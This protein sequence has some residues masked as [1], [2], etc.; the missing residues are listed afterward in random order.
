MRLPSKLGR[1]LLEAS[2]EG[3]DPIREAEILSRRPVKTISINRFAGYRGGY[4]FKILEIAGVDVTPLNG[5]DRYVGIV[6]EGYELLDNAIHRGGGYYIME[7][8]SA[9]LHLI[10]ER[11]DSEKGVN[12]ILDVAAAP[13]GKTFIAA[14]TYLESTIVA[15]EPNRARHRRLVNNVIRNCLHN[16]WVSRYRGEKLPPSG[17]YDLVIFDAPCSGLDLL[18]KRPRDVVTNL[19]HREAYANL[20]RTIVRHISSMVREGGY[21]VYST[22]TLTREE[23]IDVYWEAVENGWEPID[24]GSHLPLKV[25]S[26]G[27]APK[28][29]FILPSLNEDKFHGNTGLLYVAVFRKTDGSGWEAEN[30]IPHSSYKPVNHMAKEACNYTSCV[31]NGI[32]RERMTP[33][34]TVREAEKIAEL[35][36][37]G[38]VPYNAP[39]EIRGKVLIAYEENG[40]TTPI[41]LAEY[42]S[43]MLRI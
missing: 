20:Q 12:H 16:V 11:L 28:S 22:C 14:N 1:L 27:E 19:R 36:R 13:G 32:C 39:P 26:P 25:F 43:G 5:L 4:I 18:Y 10:L 8:A 33:I 29:F 42:F 38:A 7:V 9:A 21:L 15:N 41:A 30:T 17:P 3:I 6:T 34:I 40:K 24:L 2:I 35:I 37:R 23:T 31:Y